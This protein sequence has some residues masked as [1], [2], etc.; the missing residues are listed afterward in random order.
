MAQPYKTFAWALLEKQKYPDMRQYPGGPPVPPYDN[1]A[2]TLPLQMG[3]LCDQ[4]DEPFEAKL[5]KIDSGPLPQGPGRRARAA[6][7][8][9]DSA[10]QRLV[11]HGHRPAQGQAEVWRTKAKAA[12][13]GHR[14]PGRRL[15]R[16][17]LRRGEEGPAGPGREVSTWPSSTS[18]TSAGL[19]KAPVKFPRIGLFQSWRGNMDEGWTRY[20][21]DDMGIPYKT[22]HN[23][24]I[25]GTK[26]KKPDLG[27]TSTS[28][29][30]PTRTPTPSRAPGPGP[31]PAGRAGPRRLVDGPDVPA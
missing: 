17:E 24:D 31:D 2:W 26:D 18:T 13:K 15:H 21:F 6:Y 16:Q 20:V 23:D 12:V 14:S 11:C 25:K 10:G 19:D 22:L 4:I 8:V 3:V 5:E 9:L 28:S 7:F 30:S 1:A 27:P 29:S